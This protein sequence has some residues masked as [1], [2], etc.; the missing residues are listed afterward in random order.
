MALTP[1]GLPYPLGTDKVVDGDDAIHAL[2]VAL[3]PLFLQAVEGGGVQ[4]VAGN[5][6]KSPLAHVLLT[7]GLWLIQAGA[8]IAVD[9]VRDGY[10]MSVFVV[11]TNTELNPA[12]RSPVNISPL[13]D[14]QNLTIRS[15]VV[16]ITANTDVQVI[17]AP[18]NAGSVLRLT[19]GG[20][21][22]AAWITAVRIRG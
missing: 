9:G 16:T 22:P 6:V 15:A 1:G 19:S 14:V 2:A 17:A 12:L 10:V 11:G 3:D 13:G 4:G 21:G 20:G 18:A 5:P 7:P 8:G